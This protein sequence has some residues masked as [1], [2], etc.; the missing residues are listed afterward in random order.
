[1]Q[2]LYVKGYKTNKQ[3]NFKLGTLTFERLS[4]ASADVMD[5]QK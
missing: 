4:V 1:M 2:V 3:Q 5:F